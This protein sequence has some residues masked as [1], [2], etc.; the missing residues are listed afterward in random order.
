MSAVRNTILAALFL[1]LLASCAPGTLE[2]RAG[3]PLTTGTAYI[4]EMNITS[5]SSAR[6]APLEFRFDGVSQPARPTGRPNQYEVGRY[7]ITYND[8]VSRVEWLDVVAGGDVLTFS[9]LT[10]RDINIFDI[11]AKRSGMASV[12][13][14]R[15]ADWKFGDDSF[16]GTLFDRGAEGLS[17]ATRIGTCRVARK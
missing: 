17:P 6:I 14:C 15:F 11:T 16:D 7:Y 3:V 4:Y 2:R 9:S 8:G 1:A 13:T 10:F 5:I 12:T